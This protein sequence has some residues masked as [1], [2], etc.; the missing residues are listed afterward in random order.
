MEGKRESGK[1]RVSVTGISRALPAQGALGSW[2]SLHRTAWKPSSLR[3]WAP[4]LR[5]GGALPR[6]G[7]PL[8]RWALGAQ[9]AGGLKFLSQEESGAGWQDHLDLGLWRFFCSL[10]QHHPGHSPLER[11]SKTLGPAAAPGCLPWVFSVHT[12]PPLLLHPTVS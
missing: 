8:R 9:G 5:W 1:L 12:V 10:T 7:S 3:A 11:P 2:F 6:E 4:G